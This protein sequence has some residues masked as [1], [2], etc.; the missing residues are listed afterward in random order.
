MALIRSVPRSATVTA[1]GEARAHR[2]P[3]RRLLRDPAQGARARGEDALAVPRRPGRPARHTNSELHN[4]K[5]ELAAEDITTPQ[6]KE[7]TVCRVISATGPIHQADAADGGVVASGEVAGDSF[8]TIGAGGRLAIKNGK[9]T[10]ET[11]FEGGGDVRVCV[12]GD[13]EMWMTTGLFSSVVGA[14]ESPGAEVWIVMPQGVVRYGSGA[15]LHVNVGVKAEVQL[16]NGGA[17][18]YPVDAIATSRDAEAPH[19][20]DG[21]YP[22][23]VGTLTLTSKKAPSQILGDCEQA[24]KAAHD[25]AVQIETRDASLAEAAPRHVVLRQRAHALCS[26]AELV[27]ARFVRSRRAR[28]TAP[29]GPRRGRK[30]A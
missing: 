26:V 25:L 23:P 5:R 7:P 12:N 1:E 18:V 20:T 3:A 22:A 10:R 9:T 27:A 17:F 29:A 2:D 13:E 6:P 15:R 28:E 30:V 8:F 24:A 14:G 21:W 4:A 16:Q 11:I 19:G